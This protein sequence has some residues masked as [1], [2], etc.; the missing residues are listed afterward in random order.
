MKKIDF[1]DI[2]EVWGETCRQRF[3]LNLLATWVI[4]AVFTPF[5]KQ[6]KSF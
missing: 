5:S 2:G 1:P 6:P 4:F 3:K